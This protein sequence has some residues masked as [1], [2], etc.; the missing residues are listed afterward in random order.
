[1]FYGN[2]IKT[3]TANGSGIRLSLFVSGCTNHCEGCFQP[4]TWDFR[5]GTPYTKETE[6]SI[7]DELRKGYYDGLTILGGEPFEYANQG[8]ILNLIRRVKEE[9]PERTIWIYTGFTLDKDLVPG[10]CRYVS[11]ITDKILDSIDVLVDGK[12]VKEL[13]N[14]MLNFRGSENQRIIDMNASRKTKTI[15]LSSLND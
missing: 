10:G 13:R 15:V 8:E 12:F 5:Y 11:G 4:Q 6:N 7:I 9:L 1:M 14:I 2:I 3:D